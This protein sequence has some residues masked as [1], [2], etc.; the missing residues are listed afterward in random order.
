MSQTS[1]SRVDVAAA[2]PT[3]TLKKQSGRPRAA[4]IGWEHEISGW[5]AQPGGCCLLASSGVTS[6]AI[7]QRE[8]ISDDY[9]RRAFGFHR[10]QESCGTF[11]PPVLATFAQ[12]RS[13]T[14][15]FRGIYFYSAFP[16]TVRPR[17]T[18]LCCAGRRFFCDCYRAVYHHMAS[19]GFTSS[20]EPA[21]IEAD[22]DISVARHD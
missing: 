8:T 11:C 6:H 10:G 7:L 22:G 20:C 4:G 3:R 16:R 9:A 21:G 13:R 17:A 12:L 5:A 14:S 1:R 2:D 19:D 15:L 18:Y